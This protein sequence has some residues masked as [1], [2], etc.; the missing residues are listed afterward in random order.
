MGN[1]IINNNITIGIEGLVGAGKT[2][3]CREL[4]KKVPNSIILHGGNLYRGIVFALMSSGANM[5]KI[6]HKTDKPIDIKQ[7]MDMLK[8]EL[9]IE[10]RESV[11]Y[12]NGKEINEDNLQSDKISMA[13]SKIA[14]DADNAKFYMFGK[15]LIDTY[16]KQYNLII[17]G[18]DLMK[19]YPELDYHF[20]VTADIDTRVERKMHQYENETITREELKKHIEERDMLQEQAGFYKRYSKTIDVDVTECKNA[21]ESAMKIL[22]KIAQ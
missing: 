5:N 16:K 1:N 10:N 6:M 12:V 20:F 9:K 3:I 7:M 8:V 18:R 13:V 15:K 4:L 19:I 2:S 11:V 14:K 21:E 22:E 17:S